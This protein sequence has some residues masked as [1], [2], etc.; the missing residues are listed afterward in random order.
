MV[1][2][3]LLN[4]PNNVEFIDISYSKLTK[5]P[6]LSKFTNLKKL[7]IGNNFLISLNNLPDTLVELFCRTNKIKKLNNLPP[8]LK[9]LDCSNNSIQNIDNLPI[10]LNTLVCG[11]TIYG[12]DKNILKINHLPQL[13]KLKLNDFKINNIPQTLLVLKYYNHKIKITYK[14]RVY[15]QNH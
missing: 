3:Y 7:N 2:Q 14:K 12:Y 15:Y 1:E 10:S 13:L 8:F 6:D 11:N 4:L 5:L 9:I